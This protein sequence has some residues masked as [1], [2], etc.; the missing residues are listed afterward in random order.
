MSTNEETVKD[1]KERLS[2]ARQDVADQK[3]TITNLTAEKKELKRQLKEA[4]DRLSELDGNND[5]EKH[6]LEG[7]LKA[8]K[9]G[10]F[11]KDIEIRHADKTKPVMYGTYVC[12]VQDDQRN[13]FFYLYDEKGVGFYLAATIEL[14]NHISLYHQQNKRL[15]IH[16]QGKKNR[17]HQPLLSIS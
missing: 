2:K 4:K 1:L 16:Y 13:V 12:V 5:T 7:K 10:V 9:T 11:N 3:A 14:V 17:L 6:L 8:L 15:T